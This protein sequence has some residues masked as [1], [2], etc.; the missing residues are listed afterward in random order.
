MGDEPQIKPQ[1]SG[2]WSPLL[3]KWNQPQ[4][5][6]TL[7]AP[8]LRQE[9]RRTDGDAYHG[10]HKPEQCVLTATVLYVD[11]PLSSYDVEEILGQ[12]GVE[13]SARQLERWPARFGPTVKRILGKYR[14]RF[15]RVW[16]VDEKFTPHKR[17][18]SAGR[19][20]GRT[21]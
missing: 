11:Y 5:Q 13:A 15:S 12:F 21:R 6:T 3:E 18:A 20:S 1:M 9:I 8:V 19:G 10:L 7:Q 16:H 4:G 2:I 17:S 14:V